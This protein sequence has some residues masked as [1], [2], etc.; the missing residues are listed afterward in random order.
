MPEKRQA[1][2]GAVRDLLFELG[3][4]ELPPKAL[5]RLSEALGNE[6]YLGLN[7]AKLATEDLTQRY[8]LYATPRRLA[9]WFPAVRARQPDQ[10]VERRGPALKAAYDAAGNPTSALQGFARSCGVAI[11]RLQTV[12]TDKG[13]W[14]VHRATQ[15]GAAAAALVPGIIDA[16]LAKLPIPKRMRWGAGDALFVRPVHWVV[17]L[18]GEQVIP[19]TILGVKT[20]RVSRGHR[21]MARK[22]VTLKRASKDEYAR[23]LRKAF[24]SAQFDVRKN[25]IEA[26]VTDAARA[27]KGRAQI[28]PALLDEVAALVEWPHAIA[29]GFDPGF[30]QVPQ[31]ALIATMRDNQ[32]YFAI[33]DRDGRLLPRF[34]VISNI[35]AKSDA[36][37]R[38]GNERVLRA[39]FSDAQFFWDADRKQRLD[40]HVEGLKQ[41]VFHHKLGSLYDKTERV[42]RLVRELAASFDAN[43]DEAARAATLAKADL[44][45]AMVNEFPELQGVMGRYYA[46]HDGESANVA[47]AI[48]EHYLPRFAGDAL[49]ATAAGRALAVA[50][51][52]DTLV[53]MFGAGEPPTGDKDPFALRRAALGA[54]RILIEGGHDVDLPALIGNARAGY[55][56]RVDAAAAAQVFEFM[57]E[58][59]RNYY[60]GEDR[61]RHF[62][63]DLVD[64]VLALKPAS[65]LDVHRRLTALEAFRRLPEAAS[66]AAA[67]KRI[68]N[69]LKQEARGA[70]NG[71]DP[72]L[73][74]DDAEKRLAAELER[75]SAQVA[76]LFERREYAQALTQ[77]A[78]LRPA[79]DVFFDRVLVMAEE[80]RVRDNRLAL[81]ERLSGLFLRVADLSRLQS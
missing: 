74:H 77:L 49:P 33:L 10:E 32:R 4:E 6:L 26:L 38:A 12:K 17:L 68:R 37:I 44:R 79:V 59:L 43:P 22:P 1:R 7:A 35:E 5:K 70:R 13:E 58:R 64:A 42:T 80:A 62:R 45:S 34:V 39:R 72:A 51:R 54:L 57:L 69:I 46:R 18:F 47:D 56:D 11:E 31:E 73:L 52:L 24:V 40:S 81:L 16:A 66:L 30:L 28:E 76:P 8:E 55:G 78:G 48:A 60:L 75:L 2:A 20:G 53:G 19:A 65:P 71:L 36:A 15:K 14:I 29:G 41:A 61:A 21:F 63:V 67:N 23:Q 9:A 27:H 3:T 50:D 25:E